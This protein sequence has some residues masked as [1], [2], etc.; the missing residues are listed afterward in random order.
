MDPC[1]NL[2]MDTKGLAVDPQRSYHASLRARSERDARA[3]A[4]RRAQALSLARQLAAILASEF[5]A[6]RVLLFGSLAHGHWYSAASDIDLAAWGLGAEDHLLALARLEE[7]SPG[8]QIDLV[9]AERLPA[10]ILEAIEA[11]GV[12]L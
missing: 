8:F 7:L 12:P 11:E 4:A 2:P 3:L 10:N 1:Y 9:R 6:T 5:G